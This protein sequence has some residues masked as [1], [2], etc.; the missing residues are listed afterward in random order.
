MADKDVAVVCDV[1]IFIVSGCANGEVWGWIWHDICSLFRKQDMVLN[2]SK[3]DEVNVLASGANL[4]WPVALRHIFQQ[5][6]SI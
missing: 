1:T 6:E 4:G 3:F 5:E 2:S